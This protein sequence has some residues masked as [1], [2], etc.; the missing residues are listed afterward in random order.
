MRLPTT[1]DRDTI[2]GSQWSV[3]HPQPLNA[4]LDREREE[5]KKSSGRREIG[6]E[7]VSFRVDEVV[8]EAVAVCIN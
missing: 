4:P 6:G 8:V 3:A 1:N 7:G 2:S 5:R